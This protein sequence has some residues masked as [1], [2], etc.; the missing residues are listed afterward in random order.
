MIFRLRLLNFRLRLLPTVIFCAAFALTLKVG[1]IWH[2]LD[3]ILAPTQAA[4][5][6]RER[7]DTIAAL[8]AALAAGDGANEEPGA[9][10]DA[11]H[12][13]LAASGS[14]LAIVQIED[15]LGVRDQANLPGLG[16]E[17]P[18]WRRRLPVTLESFATDPRLRRLA[19][20]LIGRSSKQTM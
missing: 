11:L 5:A 17:A 2:D 8:D 14:R 10:A 7:R 3:A 12:R 20:I 19:G 1:A 18:N 6:R 9:F 13:F 4:A 16:D 15:V